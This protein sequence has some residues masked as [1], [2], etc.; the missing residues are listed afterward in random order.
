MAV[1]LVVVQLYVIGSVLGFLV[2]WMA[3]QVVLFIYQWVFVFFVDVL[4]FEQFGQFYQLGVGFFVEMVDVC[5]VEVGDVFFD[6]D[7]QNFFGQQIVVGL[8]YDLGVLIGVV[9]V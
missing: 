1:G 8:Q 3:V 6:E 5:D 4:G 9:F 7:V 2:Q